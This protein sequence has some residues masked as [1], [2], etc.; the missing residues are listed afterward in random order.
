M[1][2]ISLQRSSLNF[3]PFTCS[4]TWYMAKGIWMST[5]VWGNTGGVEGMNRIVGRL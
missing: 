5:T 2:V 1:Y 3:P 4:A